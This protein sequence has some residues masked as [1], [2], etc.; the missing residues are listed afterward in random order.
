MVAAVVVGAAAKYVYDEVAGD[1][2]EDIATGTVE[3]AGEVVEVGF[4]VAEEVAELGFDV[5]EEVL[6]IGF[7]IVEVG[8]DVVGVKFLMSGVTS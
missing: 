4:E 3:I 1:L 5:A 6:D 2:I 8:F 7:D